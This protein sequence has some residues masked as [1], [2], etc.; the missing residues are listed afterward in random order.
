MLIVEDDAATGHVLATMLAREGFVAHVLEDA[1]TALSLLRSVPYDLLLV[2]L[3]LVG[4][5]GADFVA[6]LRRAGSKIPALLIS[7]APHDEIAE[8]AARCGA[9]GWLPK[10]LDRTTLL[11]AI[12]DALVRVSQVPP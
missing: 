5:P 3:G 1:E 11:L 8:M 9:N 6:I 4:M 12:D 7:G 2:D 10:P